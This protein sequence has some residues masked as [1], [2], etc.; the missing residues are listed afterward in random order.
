[1]SSTIPDTLAPFPTR[2]DSAATMKAPAGAPTYPEGASRGRRTTTR[3][4]SEQAPGYAGPKRS[5]PTSAVAVDPDAYRPDARAPCCA[6]SGWSR[7]I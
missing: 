1:M 2:K 3:G 4:L 5:T 7:P 6:A